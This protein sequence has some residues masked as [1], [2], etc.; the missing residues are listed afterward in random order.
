MGLFPE[1]GITQFRHDSPAHEMTCAFEDVRGCE[2]AGLDRRFED[3][4]TWRP[5]A[6][7]RFSPF[8]EAD[9]VPEPCRVQHGRTLRFRPIMGAGNWGADCGRRLLTDVLVP[10]STPKTILVS[11]V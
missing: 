3:A 1:M 4:K 9:N 10:G 8:R 11:L 6:L 5:T 7:P 2:R